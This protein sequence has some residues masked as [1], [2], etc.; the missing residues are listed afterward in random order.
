MIN[1]SLHVKGASEI[2]AK[3]QTINNKLDASEW[4]WEWEIGRWK[5]YDEFL[6]YLADEFAY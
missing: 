2:P 4:M 1:C 6:K 5:D 3:K